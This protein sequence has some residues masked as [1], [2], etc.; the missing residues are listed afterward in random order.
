MK[1]FLL[2]S[3]SLVSFT[4]GQQ[5]GIDSLQVDTA[6]QLSWT[7]SGS[8]A[9][10][11]GVNLNFTPLGPDSVIATYFFSQDSTRHWNQFHTGSKY[12]KCGKPHQE[13]Y[14]IQGDSFPNASF[15]VRLW[16]YEM[17]SL[18][19]FSQPSGQ[20]TLYVGDSTNI[21]GTGPLQPMG[22]SLS[23][24]SGKTFPFSLTPFNNQWVWKPTLSEVSFHCVLKAQLNVNGPLGDSAFTKSG[25]FSIAIRGNAPVIS[26]LGPNP[27]TILV[28]T[29][30]SEWGETVTDNSGQTSFNVK[31]SGSVPISTAGTYTLN[32]NTT[33]SAGNTAST[34]TRTVVVSPNNSL[35]TANSFDSSTLSSISITSNTATPSSD[36]PDLS[37]IKSLSFTYI[38][39]PIGGN[40]VANF[41]LTLNSPPYVPQIVLMQTLNQSYPQIFITG[42][43]IPGLDGTYYIKGTNSKVVWVR[44]N[45]SFSITFIP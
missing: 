17:D 35:L 13:T 31:I 12:I 2:L 15:Q 43:G 10:T 5:L 42:T 3:I 4:F 19:K 38:V 41:M 7:K 24:D 8:L 39:D 26:L 11:L 22:I 32:Y 1:N 33:D 6:V 25:M 44:T 21:Q 18:F 14:V 27:D 34:V 40:R 9:D 37:T 20:E 16:R 45:G 36:G 29:S 23:I 30:Y 28:G